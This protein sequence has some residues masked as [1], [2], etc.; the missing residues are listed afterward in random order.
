LENVVE[1]LYDKAFELLADFFL[2]DHN[3]GELSY[4]LFSKKV[5]Q[6]QVI[7]VFKYSSYVPLV[8]RVI[9]YT[10]RFEKFNSLLSGY[11]FHIV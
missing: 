4:F 8:A 1:A 10:F 9:L 3:V 2:P 7:I 6:P 11:H 5:F